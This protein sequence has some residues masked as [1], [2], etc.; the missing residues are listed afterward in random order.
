MRVL[1][2]WKKDLYD[3]ELRKG[4]VAGEV[5]WLEQEDDTLE[6][7]DGISEAM[8]TVTSLQTGEAPSKQYITAK[9]LLNEVDEAI[10][11][12]D[13]V[14][15]KYDTFLNFAYQTEETKE[16]Q[17]V[18][19]KTDSHPTIIDA[20]EKIVVED[21]SNKDIFLTVNFHRDG[22][23]NTFSASTTIDGEVHILGENV[24]G[25]DN[26]KKV[27]DS[28]AESVSKLHPNSNIFLNSK[29]FHIETD[30]SI[31]KPVLKNHGVSIDDINAE[32]STY[33]EP[34]MGQIEIMEPDLSMFEQIETFVPVS[35]EELISSIEEHEQTNSVRVQNTE[36]MTQSTPKI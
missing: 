4:F 28:Y 3:P 12:A 32:L 17:E 34:S 13:A 26:I 10:K 18:M 19:R 5:Y 14:I 36:N 25:I 30:R 33:S 24:T 7:T 31:D 15:S 21:E 29:P 22:E 6:Q 2:S 1:E 8:R 23:N 9:E 20:E 16:I 35:K 11:Y 27:A